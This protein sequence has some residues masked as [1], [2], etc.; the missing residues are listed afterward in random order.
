ML[1]IATSLGHSDTGKGMAVL[2]FL[3]HNFIL[4]CF[5]KVSGQADVWW[6][7]QKMCVAMADLALPSVRAGVLSGCHLGLQSCDIG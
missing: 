6:D 4:V 2:L 3:P 7:V 1:G 5:S